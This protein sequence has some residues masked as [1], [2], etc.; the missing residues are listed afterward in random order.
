MQ[1]FLATMCYGLLRKRTHYNGATMRMLMS[2]PAFLALAVI[3]QAW[4]IQHEHRLA[5]EGY[6]YGDAGL[7]A[8]A[9]HSM[10]NDGD[11]DLLNQCFPGRETVDAALPNLEGPHGREF[12]LSKDDGVTLK[13][14]PVFP[15]LALP[16]YALLGKA[17]L[18]VFNLLILNLMLVLMAVLGGSSWASRLMVLI[19]FVTT[20]L[21]KYAFSFSPDI[22]LC[23]LIL[24]S[25]WASRECRPIVSGLLAGLAVSTKI[26]VAVILLPLPLVLWAAQDTRF[27]KSF[28]QLI[29]GGIVGMIPGAIFNV[30]QFGSPWVNGYGRQME[31]QNGV[32]GLTDHVSLFNEPLLQGMHN[33]FL[34]E[35]LGLWPTAPLWFLW[36]IAFLLLVAPRPWW[37][38][39][40]GEGESHAPHS[41][42][43]LIGTSSNPSPLGGE[44]GRENSTPLGGEERG[45]RISQRAEVIA[46]ALMIVATLALFIP[47][48]GWNGTQ[49]GNR[50]LFPAVTLGFVLMARA[51]HLRIVS[52]LHNVRS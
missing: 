25:I 14:S 9:T 27:I 4:N 41:T 34:N 47:F 23:V 12:A 44:G 40:G 39:V 46:M 21:W 33:I 2:W 32:I 30:W 16:F 31:V 19:C 3:A 24:G 26:Y 20:P 7:Y 5:P 50:Y 45:K 48:A 36:P 38:G 10:L 52:S 17:G 35:S 15:T 6:L 42:S 43:L 8:A 18:L 28:G 22:F 37:R 1:A 51:A 49:I 29:L 13:Q 11:L